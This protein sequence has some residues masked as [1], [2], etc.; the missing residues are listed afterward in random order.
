MMLAQDP[1][2]LEPQEYLRSYGIC[3]F[4]KEA[5]MSFNFWFWHPNMET[6]VYPG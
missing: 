2:I 1:Q 6:L 5:G 4:F 3:L